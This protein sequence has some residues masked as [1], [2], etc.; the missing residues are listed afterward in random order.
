MPTATFLADGLNVLKKQLNE[1][2]GLLEKKQT[3]EVLPQETPLIVIIAFFAVV[4]DIQ[5]LSLG[6]L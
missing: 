5:A 1:P 6:F 2:A 3:C 4:G